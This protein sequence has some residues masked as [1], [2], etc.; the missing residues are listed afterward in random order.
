[1]VVGSTVGGDIAWRVAT[2]TT[3]ADLLRVAV[4]SAVAA[5]PRAATRR[6]IGVVWGNGTRLSIADRPGVAIV[7]TGARSTSRPGENKRD[8]N[9]ED[10]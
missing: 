8:G 6:A 4:L 5:R 7:A 9:S 3:C 2:L 10:D 1:V